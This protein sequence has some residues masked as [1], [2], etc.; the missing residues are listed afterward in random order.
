MVRDNAHFTVAPHPV[1]LP[2]ASAAGRGGR[3]ST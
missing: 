1:P 2:T 3:I